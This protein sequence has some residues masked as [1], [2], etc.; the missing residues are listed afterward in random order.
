MTITDLAI[1]VGFLI[2]LSAAAERLVDFIKTLIPWLGTRPPT[3]PAPGEAMPMPESMR[4]AILQL[5]AFGAAWFSAS[6][7]SGSEGGVTRF[8]MWGEMAFAAGIKVPV[9]IV[10]ILGAAGSRF[11]K[12]ILEYVNAL[13]GIGTETL[14]IKRL[15]RSEKESTTGMRA[16]DVQR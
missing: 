12:D 11:W 5:L 2:A 8:D 3:D 1:I 10:G 13:K 4:R 6:W 16:V 7:F 15:E 9:V 14:N